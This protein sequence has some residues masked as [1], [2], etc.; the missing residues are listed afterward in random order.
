MTGMPGTEVLEQAASSQQ[1]QQLGKL[2]LNRYVFRGQSYESR[3]GKQL[4]W[5]HEYHESIAPFKTFAPDSISGWPR[6]CHS[7]SIQGFP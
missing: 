1:P 6:M 7:L 5:H 4:E 2:C 3:N